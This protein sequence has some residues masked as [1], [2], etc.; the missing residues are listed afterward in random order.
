VRTLWWSQDETEHTR[1]HCSGFGGLATTVNSRLM[2]TLS[3]QRSPIVMVPPTIGLTKW[4]NRWVSWFDREMRL[5]K[6]QRMIRWSCGTSTGPIQSIG[7]L[8]ARRADPTVRLDNCSPSF[9]K[10][11][12][13][14]LDVTGFKFCPKIL[15][16]LN[17]QCTFSSPNTHFSFSNTSLSLF[18]SISLL[19]FYVHNTVSLFLM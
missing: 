15:D 18:L 9:Y 6:S 11:C 14:I 19:L 10:L 12:P 7:S 1:G 3:Q 16:N 13:K 4:S 5:K 8:T 17:S 2:A